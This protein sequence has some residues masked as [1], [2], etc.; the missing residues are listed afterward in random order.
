MKNYLPVEK[1]GYFHHRKT[2]S[3]KETGCERKPWDHEVLT[4]KYRSVGGVGVVRHERFLFLTPK[5][6]KRIWGQQCHET[7]IVRTLV[8]ETHLKSI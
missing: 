2:L 4:Y 8:S 6:V 5:R 7:C 1:R 3:G